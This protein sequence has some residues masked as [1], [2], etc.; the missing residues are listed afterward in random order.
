[1]EQQ[2]PIHPP[3]PQPPS[4]KIKDEAVQTDILWLINFK[5]KS[6]VTQIKID[7]KKLLNVYSRQKS[8]DL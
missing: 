4:P 5:K 6:L 8:C 1:M 3:P 2:T 7:F